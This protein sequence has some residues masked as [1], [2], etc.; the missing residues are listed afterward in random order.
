MKVAID[1]VS[2]ITIR[3]V[4]RGAVTIGDEV[5]RENVVLLRDRIVRDWV[6]KDLHAL[7]I[8]DLGNA[9]AHQPEIIL[10]G[11]GWEGKSFTVAAGWKR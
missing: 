5:I 2:A 10:F 11:T 8:T 7:T 1:P 9:L 6:A 4:E 3:H